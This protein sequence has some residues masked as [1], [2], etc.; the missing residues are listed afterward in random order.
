MNSM[1][2]L[3]VNS[4][5]SADYE[6][7]ICEVYLIPDFGKRLVFSQDHGKIMCNLLLL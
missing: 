2:V 7:I 6:L 4:V 3:T 1:C 5:I